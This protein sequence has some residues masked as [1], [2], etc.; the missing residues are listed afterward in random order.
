[1]YLAAPRKSLFPAALS[2]A[3]SGNAGFLLLTGEHVS[4]G[5][6]G[7]HRKPGKA[8]KGA[9]I[10]GTAAAA[11]VMVAGAAAPA[12]AAPRP[13]EMP[14]RV[15][16]IVRPD[17]AWFHWRHVA[18]LE[19]LAYLSGL[20]REHH[21]SYRSYHYSSPPAYGQ[22]QQYGGVY[23]YSAIERLWVSAGGPSWAASTAACIA[24]HESGGNPNAESPS[25]DFG[26]FQIHGSWGP[27]MAT[28]NPYE[29]AV[30]A[31]KISGG[32]QNWSPWTTAGS[33]GV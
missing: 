28:F 10:A 4:S 23:S 24:E 33:C 20:R 32:G 14:P 16:A 15:I 21:Y 18:H 26:I 7:K 27:A 3:G 19:H 22:P 13:A 11:G 25:W 2:S 5:N 12:V 29:N 1:M 31:V 17:G 8:R 6:K 9:V 30:A